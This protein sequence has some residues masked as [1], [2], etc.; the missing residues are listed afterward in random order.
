[1][2]TRNVPLVGAALVLVAAGAPL[3]AQ[4]RAELPLRDGRVVE[5]LGLRR[6]T[7][8]MLQD[9]LARYAPGERLERHSC[10]AALRY[11]LGFADA[12]ATEVFGSPDGPS[13]IVVSAWKSAMKKKH[14]CSSWLR[15]CCRIAP[16]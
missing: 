2:I 4:T 10:A 3:R 5:V 13:R 12:A 1:M 11:R 14:S 9:S 7:L 6:W 16:K 8:A 15:M